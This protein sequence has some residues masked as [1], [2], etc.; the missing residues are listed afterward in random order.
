MGTD[1]AD[2]CANT[3]DPNDEA[4]DKWPPDINDD[5]IAN[6][7]DLVHFTPPYFGASPPDPNYS[8]RKDLNGDGI[9]NLL[10]IV[11]LTPPMFGQRCT[12]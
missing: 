9:I 7:L 5:Q 1:P 8:E 3:P 12:P 10:D 4:D 6:I 2:A 11:R